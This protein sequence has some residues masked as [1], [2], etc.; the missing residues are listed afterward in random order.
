MG[1]DPSVVTRPTAKGEL[2]ISRTSHPSATCCIRV[3]HSET[4]WPIRKRRKLRWRS[5]ANV[6]RSRR[7]AA[8]GNADAAVMAVDTHKSTQSTADSERG[9]GA[10]NLPAFGDSIEEAGHPPKAPGPPFTR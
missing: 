2:V 10:L 7:A 6:E 8:R 9:E 4:N 5:A 3:P 1:S